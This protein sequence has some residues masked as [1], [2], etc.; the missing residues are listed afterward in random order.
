MVISPALQR[1]VS[2]PTRTEPESRRDGAY[3]P[4]P[5][6]VFQE[7]WNTQ[8]GD[9]PLAN[10][11]KPLPGAPS[12]PLFLRAKSGEPASERS[13]Q[14]PA[15]PALSEVERYLQIISLRRR[16]IEA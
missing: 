16:T 14:A 13:A 9:S 7:E 4:R 11:P 3:A 6:N 1:G 2:V 10:S 12:L 15:E 8:A 5:S